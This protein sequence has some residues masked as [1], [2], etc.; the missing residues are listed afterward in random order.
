MS[1]L[2]ELEEKPVQLYVKEYFQELNTFEAVL[3][4]GEIVEFDPFVSN[5][6]ELTDKEYG[7]GKGAEIKGKTFLITQFI[8][9]PDCSDHYEYVIIPRIGGLEEV[10]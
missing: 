5:A 8:V 6:L 10:A 1:A 3:A 4:S 2:Y 7:D 9:L